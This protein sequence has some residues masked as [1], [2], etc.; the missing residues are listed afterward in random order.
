MA[1][2]NRKGRPSGLQ[3]FTP[4]LGGN[5]ALHA[6]PPPAPGKSP[7]IAMSPRPCPPMA[8][9]AFRRAGRCSRMPRLSPHVDASAHPRYRHRGVRRKA[10]GARHCM[11]RNGSVWLCGVEWVRVDRGQASSS[12]APLVNR[13]CHEPAVKPGGWQLCVG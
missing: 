4:V 1:P 5:T 9:R 3:P 13:C 10:A 6:M 11:S 2:K 12:R 7:M 8:A